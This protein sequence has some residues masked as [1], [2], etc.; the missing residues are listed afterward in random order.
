[1]TI[2][3]L[4]HSCF[5][6]ESGG[7]RVLLDPYHEVQGLPDIETEADAVYCSHDH[8]DHGYTENVRL[9]TGRESPFAVREIQTFHD[10]KGGTLRGKNIIHT[11]TAEG[12]T[13]AHLGDLGHQLSEEQ[14]AA[15]G[16][17]DAV[18]IPVGGFYTI[19]AAGAKA[20]ADAIG[21]A[22][23]I[24]MHYRK[25]GVGFDVL[26]TVEDFTKLYPQEQVKQY[27]SN[28]LTLT[29]DTPRQVAVL[30]LPQ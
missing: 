24:P 11:F 23:V 25:G 21:A 16:R 15:I 26:G 9:T 18:L 3:W 2:T 29:K 10:D 27:P 6:L 30:S 1:M 12:V 13:L 20:V 5:M 17:C 19:D 22:V 28:V 7:F 8:F 4:G 14:L